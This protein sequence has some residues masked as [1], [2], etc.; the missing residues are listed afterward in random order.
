MV[1]YLDCT[2]SFATSD[3]LLAQLPHT[4]RFASTQLGPLEWFS[5]TASIKLSECDATAF[6]ALL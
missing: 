1:L 4:L 6:I 3:S 5:T 2:V